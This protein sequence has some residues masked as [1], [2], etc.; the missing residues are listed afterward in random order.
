MS[1]SEQRILVVGLGLSGASALRHLVREGASV[2]VTDSRAAPAGIDA[3]RAEYPQVEF[4]LGAF[5]A[6]EP[7]AQ[8]AMA[9]VSPGIS[10]DEPFVRMLAA[11]GVEIVGDIELFARALRAAGS[12]PTP[13]VVGITGS[14]GKST[15]TTLVGEM[16]A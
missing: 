14:N 16:S 4:R 13:R 6:P 2:V 8:F 11:A 15:V 10:L 9:V 7:Q 3:L 1:D 5:S 12:G